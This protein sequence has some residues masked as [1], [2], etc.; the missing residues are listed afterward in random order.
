LLRS[1]FTSLG[2]ISEFTSSTILAAA[3]ASGRA[4]FF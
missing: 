2:A 1:P 4:I 3:P